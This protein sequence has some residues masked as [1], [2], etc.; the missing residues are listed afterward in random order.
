MATEMYGYISGHLVSSILCEMNDDD[1][2]MDNDEII[3]V[4]MKHIP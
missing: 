4:T 1:D 2:D 3:T